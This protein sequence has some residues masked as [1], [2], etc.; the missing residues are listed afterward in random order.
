MFAKFD[1]LYDL[2]LTV[3]DK[4]PGIIEDVV[5]TIG[6]VMDAVD[7]IRGMNT[8]QAIVGQ[9]LAHPLFRRFVENRVCR[10]AVIKTGKNREEVQL[11]YEKHI[12][13]VHLAAAC[14]SANLSMPVA[15]GPIIDWL[16][17][18]NWTQVF[19][20]ISKIL[21]ILIPILMALAESTPLR[22]VDGVPATRDDLTAALTSGNSTVQ[23]S[24]FAPPLAKL[25][26]Q[27]ETNVNLR[28]VTVQD[29]VLAE[30]AT[31]NS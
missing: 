24:W 25:I 14:T 5:K 30:L 6:D 10:D 21:A 12:T 2:L 29:L 3:R 13:N 9:A 28:E 27:A 19:D 11:A 8:V 4:A 1:C 26:S 7:A 31:L 22:G 20:V 23:R 18:V 16:K 15:G 17:T